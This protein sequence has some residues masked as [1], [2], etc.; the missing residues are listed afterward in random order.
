MRLFRLDVDGDEGK[1]SLEELKGRRGQLTL[2]RVARTPSDGPRLYFKTPDFD[3]RDSS[4]KLGPK[5]DIRA[6]GGNALVPPGLTVNRVHGQL[7][8]RAIRPTRHWP[9]A[10]RRKRRTGS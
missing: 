4:I 10:N 9:K 7:G 6:N 1:T 8:S 5:L 2:V 3:H